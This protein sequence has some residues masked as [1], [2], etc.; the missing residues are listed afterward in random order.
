MNKLDLVEHQLFILNERTK[1]MSVEF[2]ALKADVLRLVAAYKESKQR[3][4]EL[5]AQLANPP[6]PPAPDPTPA[7]VASLAAAIA[8]ELPPA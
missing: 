4:A 1:R 2:D 8:A 5:T 6:A 3:N 7:D